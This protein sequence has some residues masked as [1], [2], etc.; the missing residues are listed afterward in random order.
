[1]ELSVQALA[2]NETLISGGFEYLFNQ[3]SSL[4]FAM[5]QLGTEDTSVTKILPVGVL[6]PVRGKSHET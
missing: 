3:Q 6:I 4:G 1:M 5:S 2:C